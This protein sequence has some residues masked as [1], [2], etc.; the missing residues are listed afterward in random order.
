LRNQTPVEKDSTLGHVIKVQQVID[1]IVLSELQNGRRYGKQ[2][3]QVIIQSLNG[4]GVND[5][6]LS[7]RLRVLAEKGHATS[8]WEDDHR[9]N[10]YYEITESGLEYFNQLVKDL[11]ER[12][13]LALKVYKLFDKM[14][15]KYD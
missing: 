3:D 11:P 4:V 7:Q 2:L 10:R 5:S 8:Q 1:F 15:K 13:D 6:Y 12:V 9:Y 14:I